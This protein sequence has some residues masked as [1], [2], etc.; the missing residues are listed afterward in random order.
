M[1]KSPHRRSSCTAPSSRTSTQECVTRFRCRASQLTLPRL[2]P[3]RMQ[4]GSGC[5]GHLQCLAQNGP[6]RPSQ[7]LEAVNIHCG[8]MHGFG[9]ALADRDGEGDGCEENMILFLRRMH[10]VMSRP[11]C[12]RL[13]CLLASGAEEILSAG[14]RPGVTR[15]VHIAACHNG[16]KDTTTMTFRH[17]RRPT[18]DVAWKNTWNT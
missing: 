6:P 7:R 17:R 3:A 15:D 8:A 16:K 5:W 2:G 4:R 13:L 12:M 10:L 18:S 11:W 1:Q 9:I 14:L